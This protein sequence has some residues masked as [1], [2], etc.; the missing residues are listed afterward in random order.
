MQKRAEIKVY[1]T[2][3]I[4]KVYKYIY[5][6]DRFIEREYDVISRIKH[7]YEDN[8]PIYYIVEANSYW[9][10]LQG[11]TISDAIRYASGDF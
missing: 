1:T 2:K 8:S 4:K 3:N 7:H 11:G 9:S 5:K 6:H 10:V